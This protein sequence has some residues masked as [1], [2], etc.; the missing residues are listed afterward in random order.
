MSSRTRRTGS[1]VVADLVGSAPGT[2]GS[3]EA[4]HH[5]GGCRGGDQGIGPMHHRRRRDPVHA[6]RYVHD[7]GLQSIHNEKMILFATSSVFVAEFQSVTIY[8]RSM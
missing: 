8:G 6:N 4:A 3:R 1:R 5:H 2:C 7:S